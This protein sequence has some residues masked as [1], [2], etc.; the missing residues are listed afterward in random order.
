LLDTA[1]DAPANMTFCKAL[2]NKKVCC[3]KTGFENMFEKWKGRKA[4]MKAV[5]D[6]R[7]EMYNNQKKW[8]VEHLNDLVGMAAYAGAL[9]EDTMRLAT[10]FFKNGRKNWG[11]DF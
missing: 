4:E 1:A 9:A 3:S 7:L 6:E 8:I 10:K 11:E 5:R 2:Q